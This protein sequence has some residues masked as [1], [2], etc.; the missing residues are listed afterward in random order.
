[1]PLELCSVR[2]QGVRCSDWPYKGATIRPQV[3][4]RQEKWADAAV[5]YRSAIAAQPKNAWVYAQLGNAP[6][7]AGDKPAAKSAFES[8]LQLQSDLAQAKE[9]LAA[10]EAKP[11]N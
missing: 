3:R 6:A 5:C 8:A 4:E 2:S 9:G 1:M 11:E 7:K 10:L